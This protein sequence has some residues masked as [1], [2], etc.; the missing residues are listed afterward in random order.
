MDERV[1]HG[2]H[3]FNTGEYFAC[4]EVL[5]EVWTPERGP[6]RLF[7]QS[8]I[9]VAVACYHI[10]RGNPVGASRQLHKALRKLAPY[11]PSCEG[12]DTER[13]FREARA[14]LESVEAG[15]PVTEFPK[16]VFGESAAGS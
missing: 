12:I 5:E 7:L 15:C 14:L 2:I 10:E 13:L 11:L 6:Q 16:V 8:M 1:A 9:H 3:L 4:H